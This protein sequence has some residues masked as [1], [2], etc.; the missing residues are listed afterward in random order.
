MIVLSL[1]LCLCLPPLGI[2]FPVGSRVVG[3]FIMPCGT[4]SY[5]A[6]GHDDL[7]EDFFAYNRAK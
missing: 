3:A 6:K 4:C 1:R 7:C 2:T 5:C